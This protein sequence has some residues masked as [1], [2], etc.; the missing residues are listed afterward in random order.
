MD[1]TGTPLSAAA[2][3]GRRIGHAIEVHEVLGSTNDRAGELLEVGG[4]DGV[5]VFAELQTAGRGRRG[6]TWISPPGT[7]LTMSVA[8]RPRIAAADAGRLG[9]AV[10]LA[11]RDA[12]LTVTRVDLKWPNDL[13]AP[14]GRKVGGLLVET[15]LDADRVSAAIVGIGINVNWRSSQMPAE[16]AGSATSLADLAGE[17]VDRGALLGR[18]LDRLDAEVTALDEG[19]DPTDRY[20]QACVTVGS[21]VTAELEG[22]R[23]EGLAVG[24]DESG[25]LVMEVNG[26]RRTL[27]SG[28]VVRVRPAVPA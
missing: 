17:R 27:T 2:R 28:E 22:H 5:A 23:I 25:G 15:R 3:P 11:A 12:C 20:R 24:I 19:R 21:V 26:E 18:L 13:V 8:I 16:I 14:D 9:M 4:I 10:A 6:R 1:S 7:N